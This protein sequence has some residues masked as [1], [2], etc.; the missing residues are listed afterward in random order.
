[1][2]FYGYKTNVSTEKEKK[3]KSSRIFKK[4]PET[5]RQ[6]CLEKEKAEG[7]EEIDRLI[8]LREMLAK[9]FRLPAGKISFSGAKSFS[10]KYFLFKKKISE[11]SFSRFGVVIAAKVV[12]GAVS[13]NRIKRIF[14]DFVRINKLH[15]EPG[16]DILLI[17]RPAVSIAQARDIKGE[18]EKSLIG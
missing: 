9:K 10:G 12:K 6:E 5:R 11:N 15:L 1:L 3:K 13:R 8:S 2:N 16:L 18:L 14:F 17:A 4:I 7:Q